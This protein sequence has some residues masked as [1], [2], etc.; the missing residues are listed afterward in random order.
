[1]THAL[2][3]YNTQFSTKLFETMFLD[4][5]R[6][7]KPLTRNRLYKLKKKTHTPTHTHIIVIEFK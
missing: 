6:L 5:K 4:V 7:S 2:I 1:M 3:L